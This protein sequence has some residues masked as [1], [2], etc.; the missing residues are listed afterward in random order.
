MHTATLLIRGFLGENVTGREYAD[1]LWAAIF[2]TLSIFYP[3]CPE[4]KNI[5]RASVVITSVQLPTA[6]VHNT[7]LAG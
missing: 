6:T 5:L 7:I 4:P 1:S 2:L 3:V